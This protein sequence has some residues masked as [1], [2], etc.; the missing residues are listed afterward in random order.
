MRRK[1]LLSSFGALAGVPLAAAVY[2]RF[3]SRGGQPAPP[4][5]LVRT[6]VDPDVLAD[7]VDLV[8]RV[9]GRASLEGEHIAVAIP[10][11]VSE[12][13]AYRE[14]RA[15]LDTWGRNHPDVRA[16][17]VTSAGAGPP[18]KAEKAIA[19]TVSPRETALR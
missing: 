7:L 6:R 8:R 17:I 13:S 3:T 10:D 9:R 2:R 4:R 1:R 5:L 12:D 14:L 15:L 18:K 11:G 19:A 16:A